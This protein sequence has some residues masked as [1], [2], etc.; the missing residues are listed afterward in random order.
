MLIS[1][2]DSPIGLGRKFLL[3]LILVL[4]NSLNLAIIFD[5]LFFSN[6]IFW[7]LKSESLFFEVLNLYNL[8]EGKALFIIEK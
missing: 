8:L 7:V 6:D 3:G 5:Y 4:E 2:L 1:F